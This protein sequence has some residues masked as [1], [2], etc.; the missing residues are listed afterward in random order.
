MPPNRLSLVAAIPGQELTGPG[1]AQAYGF[2]PF[3]L[4]PGERVLRRGDQVLPLPPKAFE[5]L[6][7]LV[8]NSGHLMLKGE[9]MK[10]L[11]PDSFVEEVNLANNISLLR[12]ALGDKTGTG[13]YIQTLPKLGY[14]FLPAVTSIWGRGAAAASSTRTEEAAAERVMRFIALPFR[15]VH[16]DE[17]IDF[18]GRSLPEAISASLAGLRSMTVR[19]SLLAAR[20][21][22]GEPDPR[23]IAQ[24][25]D[26][27]LLLA[28]TIVCDGDQLRV[29][30]ELVQAPT[31]TL[32]ASYICQTSRDSIFEVQESL[33]HRIVEALMLRLTERERRTLNHDVPGSARAYEF[34]L[35]ANHLQRERTVDNIVMARDLYRECVEEDPNYAAAWARLGRC[36]RFLEKFGEEGP[37][38]L[39]LA[40]W[41]FHRAFALNPDLS[42]AHNLYTQIEADLGNAQAAMVRLLAHAETH[43]N[44]PELFAGLV[45]SC[46]FC[47]LL[48]ESVTAHRRARRL[49]SKAVTSVAHT[50][51]LKGDY[52]QALES[53]DAAAGYYLDA[54]ILA[55]TGREAEAAG[56]LGRRHWSGVRAGW[57]RALIASLAASLEGDRAKSLDLVRGALAQPARDPEVKFYLARHL[58]R[59]GAHAE[60]LETIRDLVMEGFACSAALQRDAWLR[61]LSRQP[62]FQDVLDAVLGR[63]A[64]ARAAFLAA[65]GDR[66]LS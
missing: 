15:L 40:Q 45:Q 35:R 9:L 61:P 42:I 46:R 31:G 27:D 25:A 38:S 39:E 56:L 8:R 55:V 7:L 34:Y 64:E 12:K 37:E 60:A 11:W 32:L 59:D 5:A 54:A 21:A 44:D 17:R 29:S 6:L 53:Y 63:E 22:E 57:M 23:R 2:G 20:F 10:A 28:G 58:A 16:G 51:F 3:R 47:G 24:E 50:F 33:V 48:E 66:V 26:V 18:L 14:R 30:A 62:G 41:A 1:E 36:Y 19:S 65:N 13:S 4:L 52:E 49:D 43:P